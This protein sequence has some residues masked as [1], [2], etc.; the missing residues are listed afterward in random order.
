MLGLFSGLKDK[1]LVRRSMAS[2]GQFVNQ[3]FLLTGFI[4]A[5]ISSICFPNYVLSELISLIVCGPVH[6]I[7]RSI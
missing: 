6:C 3:S 5:R 1:H 4:L 2:G 7:T